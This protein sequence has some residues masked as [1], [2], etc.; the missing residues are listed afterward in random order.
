LK[1]S[2][3]VL[4]GDAKRWLD[5][6]PSLSVDLVV[7]SPP[8]PMIE[9]WDVTFSRHSESI[10]ECIRRHDGERAYELMHEELDPVWREVY[11][12][13]RPGGIA[14][15]NIGD[16]T[17]KIGDSFRVFPNHARI[18][19][20]C[21][22]LGFEALPEILWRK[23]SNKPTK[24][25]GSGM[26]PG[27]AYVTQEHEYILILRKRGKRSWSSPNQ[28]LE[29]Q[30]SAFFWEERNLWF[31]DIWE[32]LQGDR[33]RLELKN[34]RDRSAAFPF[35]LPYRLISMFSAQNDLVLD[36]FLGTG[37]TM[38]AAMA[39]GRSSLGVELDSH[40]GELLEERLKD[41]V[42]TSNSFN[43]R[44]VSNH[45]EFIEK[46]RKDGREL[47]HLNQHYRLPVMTA[48][49][50]QMLIPL[51]TRVET[52]GNDLFEVHYRRN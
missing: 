2:H 44:R 32:D 36:P 39:T 10:G 28:R 47:K 33:Q 12:L 41:V 52:K 24:F 18:L 34:T 3:S 7:T 29:R 45:R 30:R 4:Y 8:Y 35:E 42:A 1:T 16:A 11:R 20:S 50:T 27:A 23:E 5:E 51:L 37:T 15:I 31:R 13:L 17:R 19:T 22:G 46:M 6:I 49:E 38:L 21:L 43:E 26:L 25:M 9:M 48:Q 40:F 14:C